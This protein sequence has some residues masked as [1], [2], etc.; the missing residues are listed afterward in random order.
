MLEITLFDFIFLITAVATTVMASNSWARCQLDKLWGGLLNHCLLICNPGILFFFFLPVFLTLR[1][2]FYPCSSLNKI[3]QCLP[4]PQIG[5]SLYLLPGNTLILPP[6]PACT[7]Y[8]I[9]PR[10]YSLP[11]AYLTHD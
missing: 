3:M 7:H 8:T 2:Y 1:F 11:Q 9:K 10:Y 6:L 4:W 5:F